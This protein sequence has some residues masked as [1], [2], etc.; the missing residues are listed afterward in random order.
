VKILY[1]HRI[2]SKD[3]QF[4]HIEELVHALRALGHEVILVGPAVVTTES[5]GAS[6]QL[7]DNLRRLL[8]NAA[9]ELLE[10]GYN[11]VA[12]LRLLAAWRRHRPDAI[13]ERYNLFLVAGTWLK[14][15]SGLPM[16]VEVNAPLSEERAKYGGLSLSSFGRRLESYVW[17]NADSVVTVTRALARHVEHALK[18]AE[19]VVV[20]P[21][22]IDLQRFKDA[23]TTEDAKRRFGLSSR[24]VLGFTGFVREWH[25]L[26]RIIDYI[27]NTPQRPELCLFIVG[28]GPAVASLRD[29]AKSRG[30]ADRVVFAG[31]VPRDAVRDHIASFDI[32]LQP[33]VTAYASPLKMI[34]YM[35]LGRATIA[36]DLPN[37]AELLRDGETGL[38]FDPDA[39]GA[40]SRAIER[41]LDDPALRAR[42]GAA[43][44]QAVIKQRLTWQHNAERTLDLFHRAMSSN[45]AVYHS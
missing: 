9:Y 12:F 42:L 37:I 7:G 33:S 40:I 39:E 6:D 17:R 45:K 16:V 41:L 11:V 4:V 25:R 20:M 30:V 3:G 34:E 5:F 8:P 14:R 32:A 38:L 22:G 19:H 2:R 35:A 21:N 28:D 13:Y 36:P 27:A 15:V 24:V 44:Q 31:L 18:K 1:H 23:P 26:D 43:A 10:T 29:H